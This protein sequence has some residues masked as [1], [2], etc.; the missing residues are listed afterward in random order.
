MTRGWCLALIALA[1]PVAYAQIEVAVGCKR[2]Q[3]VLDQQLAPAERDRV[4]ATGETI[5]AAPAVLQLRDCG[6]EVLDAVPLEAPLARVDAALLEGA[7]HPTVLVTVDLTAEAGTYNGPLTRPFALR[8]NRLQPV[9]A[10]TANGRTEP[11]LLPLTGKAAWKKLRV[12]GKD[13]V[14]AVRSDWVGGR[15]ITRFS[16]YVP[17]RQEWSAYVRS[18]AGLWESDG[19]FPSL[20][21]FPT[22]ARPHR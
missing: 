10:K 20:N 2:I 9:H 14:L 8:G 5:A 15:F 16:R 18:Q 13:Q 11:I 21:R 4:W 22:G 17:A 1:C 7:P 6:G 19:E 12:G 3:L